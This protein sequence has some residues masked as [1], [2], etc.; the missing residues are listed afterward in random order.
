MDFHDAGYH[1][2][3]GDNAN[4]DIIVIGNNWLNMLSWYVSIVTIMETSNVYLYQ[5]RNKL[6]QL[7]MMGSKTVK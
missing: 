7:G 5:Y 1:C 4:M 2:K 6:V 3:T